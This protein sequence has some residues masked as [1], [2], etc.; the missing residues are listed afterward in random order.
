MLSPTKG[1]D[2]MLSI[3]REKTFLKPAILWV[4]WLLVTVEISDGYAFIGEE[5][6]SFAIYDLRDPARINTLP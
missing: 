4:A 2:S 1:T 6:D 3:I 5:D